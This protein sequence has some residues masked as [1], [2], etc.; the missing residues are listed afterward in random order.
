MSHLYKKLPVPVGLN[1]VLSLC[2][3]TALNV[4]AGVVFVEVP[5]GTRIDNCTL[6]GCSFI[7]WSPA[8]VNNSFLGEEK[9]LQLPD[10]IRT[11]IKRLC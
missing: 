5:V 4:G 9:G 8:I 3:Q 1:I 11:D 10:G 7:F 6:G 2:L